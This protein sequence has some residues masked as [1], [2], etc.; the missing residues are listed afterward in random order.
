MT[1]LPVR[2]HRTDRTSP[3]TRS[4]PFSTS[5]KTSPP[6]DSTGPASAATCFSGAP[7][8]SRRARPTSN[9]G[10]STSTGCASRFSGSTRACLWCKV[11]PDRARRGPA[12]GSRS[13][14]SMQ[15]CVSVSW[16]RR[17]RRSTT[18]SPRST[19]PPTRP[20][21]SSADGARPPARARATPATGSTARRSL[22]RARVR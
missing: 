1:S 15:A 18:S 7:R 6:A 10:T 19:R 11:R 16:R 2:S 5:P 20:T 3:T 12:R 17:T 9:P 13:P 22:T 8:A 4:M 14:F 21:S